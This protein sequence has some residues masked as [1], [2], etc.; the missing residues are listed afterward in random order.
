M[1]IMKAAKDAVFIHKIS[2]ALPNVILFVSGSV[3][4]YV[5]QVNC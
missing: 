1:D 3:A 2:K 4:V 5:R